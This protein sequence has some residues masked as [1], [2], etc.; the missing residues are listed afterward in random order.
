LIKP[1]IHNGKE[2][3]SLIN[4]AGAIRCQHIKECKL[5]HIYHSAQNSAPNILRTS[6]ENQIN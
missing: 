4:S 3:A 1:E 5:I 2:K 6:T